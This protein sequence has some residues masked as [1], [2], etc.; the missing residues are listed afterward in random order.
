[1]AWDR[2]HPRLTTRSASIGH[3]GELPLIE[4]TLIRLEVDRLPGGHD[5]L[6]AWAVV[7][8]DRPVGCGRRSALAGVFAQVRSGAHLSDD[9]T[10]AVL[11][12]SEAPHAQ[13]P[14]RLLG[15]KNRHPATRYDVGKTTR[16]PESI[17][18]R[19]QLR[20]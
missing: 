11:D 14:E 13:G 16:R 10:D 15:S 8:G 9:Q 2:I 4:G 19:D 20:R 3:T 6:P 18:E 1:M 12:S 5:P 7:V 17:T